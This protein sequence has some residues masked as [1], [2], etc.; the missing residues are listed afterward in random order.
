MRMVRS[1]A[2]TTTLRDHVDFH[3]SDRQRQA[4]ISQINE[5]CF[6]IADARN[7]DA[8]KRPSYAHWSHVKPLHYASI[9]DVSESIRS[10][11]LSPVEIVAAHLERTTAVQPKPNSSLHLNPDPAR[12]Q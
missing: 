11:K 3:G 8:S 6:E 7:L 9:A 2:Q 10:K 12:P 1:A 5:R 4:T